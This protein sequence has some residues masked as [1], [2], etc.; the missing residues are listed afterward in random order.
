MRLRRPATPTRGEPVIVLVDVTFFLLVFFMLVARFDATAPFEMRP[1]TARSGS[2][3]PAGGI[4]LSVAV[5]GALAVDG[6]P[7]TRAAL[8]EALRRGPRERDGEPARIRINAHRD[9]ELR[10]VLP[11][12]AELDRGAFGEIVLVVTPEAP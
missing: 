8:P 2:D 12:F 5:D 4:T 7:V 1:P 6:R 10:H 3:M 9:A 11:L